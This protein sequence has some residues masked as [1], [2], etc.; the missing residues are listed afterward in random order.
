MSFQTRLLPSIPSSI[1]KFSLVLLFL[2]VSSRMVVMGLGSYLNQSAENAALAGVLD[3]S[4]NKNIFPSSDISPFRLYTYTPLHAWIVGFFIKPFQSLSLMSRVYM[5]RLTSLLFL[6][7]IYLLLWKYYI[8]PLS[9]SG[10]AFFISIGLS[11]SEFGN[12]ALTARNDFLALLIEILAGVFF[13]SWIRTQKKWQLILFAI[14]CSLSFLTRQNMFGMILAG[15]IYL[16]T[17]RRFSSLLLINFV[18]LLFLSTSLG[19]IVFYYPDFLN[20]SFKAHA[21]LWRPFYWKQLST[22]SFFTCY[23]LFIFLL[24]IQLTKKQISPVLKFLK[25]A[26]FTSA[27]IPV[28][29]IYRPGGWLNYFFETIL[30]SLVFS[31]LEISHVQQLSQTS[32]Y[33]KFVTYSIVTLSVITLLISFFKAKKQFDST[34][35]LDYSKGAQIV[36]ELAP[37]G[38][39][40]LGAL[41]QGFGVHLRDWEIMGPEL[42]NGAHYAESNHSHFKW[43]YEQLS[44]KVKS[45]SPPVL[46]YVHPDCG[47]PKIAAP[48]ISDRRLRKLIGNYQL[49]TQ[50]YPWL[51]LYTLGVTG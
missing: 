24:I 28:L 12:Y 45:Q 46:L 32:Y 37:Q 13:I 38:G 11:I 39:I 50:I 21:V 4:E 47:E 6:S 27:L 44:L 31:S 7:L 8:K 42:L 22:L 15:E 30:F 16:L 23:S 2:G 17:N 9:I 14:S 41:A 34:A 10:M 48:L 25:I 1:L 18:Y 43:V 40:T 5:I 19:L 20:H 51:C 33:R 36:K 29:Q 49:K 35:F 26:L 3:V